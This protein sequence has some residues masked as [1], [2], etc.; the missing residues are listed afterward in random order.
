LIIDEMN[1][2]EGPTHAILLYIPGLSGVSGSQ[3]GLVVADSIADIG[4]G[5][6]Y[7]Q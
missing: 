3:Y 7:A 5:K 4:S 1:P 6:M 2:P